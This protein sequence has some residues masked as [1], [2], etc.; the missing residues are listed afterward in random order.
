MGIVYRPLPR[1]LTLNIK[2]P[3]IDLEVPF[4]MQIPQIEQVTA[5]AY[6]LLHYA[7]A[8]TG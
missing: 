1:S 5:A 2:T 4:E 6:R 7:K 3:H 8:G